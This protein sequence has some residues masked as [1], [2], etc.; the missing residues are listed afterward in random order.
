M[1]ARTV[2]AGA[3]CLAV[4]AVAGF[5]VPRIAQGIPDLGAAREE[6]SVSGWIRHRLGLALADLMLREQVAGEFEAAQ[7]QRG[8]RDAFGDLQRETTGGAA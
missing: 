7:E 4:F 5:F 1:K 3:G 2:W 6:R 8:A